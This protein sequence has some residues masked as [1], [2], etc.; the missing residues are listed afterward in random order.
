M[1]G[2]RFAMYANLR[3]ALLD[4]PVLYAR[5]FLVF[6]ADSSKLRAAESPA[7]AAR[8]RSRRGSAFCELHI[9]RS[10]GLLA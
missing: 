10:N 4:A 2:R 7:C 3:H 6:A 9:F 8:S 5:E 1:L